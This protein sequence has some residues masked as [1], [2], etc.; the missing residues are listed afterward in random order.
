MKGN[1]FKSNFFDMDNGDEFWIS[2]PRKDR[3]DRLYGGS[4]GVEIDEDIKEEYFKL[5]NGSK[6]R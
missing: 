4:R 6:S 5:I 1:G 3:N 2:G